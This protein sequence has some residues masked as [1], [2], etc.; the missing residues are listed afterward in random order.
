VRL[1]ADLRLRELA[2]PRQNDDLLLN[3][4]DVSDPVSFIFLCQTGFML[5][6]LRLLP[7]LAVR[8]FHSRRD[9]LLKIWPSVNNSPF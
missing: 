1:L 4:S 6:L 8:L 7:V 5:R 2:V 9:L 3:Q